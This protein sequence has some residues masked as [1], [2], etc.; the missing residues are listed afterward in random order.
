MASTIRSAFSAGTCEMLLAT[1]CSS[2]ISIFTV[3]IPIDVSR[4]SQYAADTVLAPW[5][6]M[7][8]RSAE[9]SISAAFSN[10]ASPFPV[11][12]TE[13]ISLSDSMTLEARFVAF[14]DSPIPPHVL[15]FICFQKAM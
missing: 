11:S 14:P 9:R 3:L 6:A 1:I 4:L 7:N 2:L 15:S 12:I 5:D 10:A 8:I 13:R